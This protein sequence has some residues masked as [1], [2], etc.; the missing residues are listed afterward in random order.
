MFWRVERL[1]KL[2]DQRKQFHFDDINFKFKNFVCSFP[3]KNYFVG[4]VL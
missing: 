3:L 4:V 1:H 2:S